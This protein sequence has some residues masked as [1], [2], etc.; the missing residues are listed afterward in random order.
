MATAR[1][2]SVPTEVLGDS[3]EEKKQTYVKAIA[4]VMEDSLPT[5]FFFSRL[6]D[7]DDDDIFGNLPRK[8]D[9][10]FFKNSSTFDIKSSFRVSDFIEKDKS[11]AEGIRD[12]KHLKTFMSGVQRLHTIAPRYSLIRSLLADS[13]DSSLKI[14]RTGESA[15]IARYSGVLSRQDSLLTFDRA[16]HAHSMAFALL[17]DF[18][19]KCLRINIASIKNILATDIRSEEGMPD[20]QELFGSADLCSCDGSH[21]MDSPAAYLVSVLHF[22]KDRLIP[23]MSTV[24]R[25]PRTGLIKSVSYRQRT[26]P[27]TERMVNGTVKDVLFERR[28]DISEIQLT[29]GNTNTPLPYI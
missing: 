5:V 3:V 7:D 25:D 4:R 14:S 22:L 29:C 23:I 18:G 28:P 15:F 1:P 2:I 6:T 10:R 19:S 21:A 24:V 13:V 9:D 26:L 12:I 8:N 11:S 16:Q 17:A 27:G 20:W